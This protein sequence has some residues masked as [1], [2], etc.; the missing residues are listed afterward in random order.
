MSY[1]ENFKDNNRLISK[2]GNSYIK[3][4]LKIK[5]K[6]KTIHAKKLISVIEKN[7]ESLTEETLEEIE[8]LDR[9]IGEC[10]FIP[11]KKS[12]SSKDSTTW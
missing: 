8:P 7:L 2:I 1:E 11:L 5:E 3:A 12:S 10:S 4:L 9:F 6:K